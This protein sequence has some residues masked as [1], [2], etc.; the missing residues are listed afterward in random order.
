MSKVSAKSAEI[1]LLLSNKSER[2]KEA[3]IEIAEEIRKGAGRRRIEKMVSD[4]VSGKVKGAEE[5]IIESP[6]GQ[7]IA[8]WRDS[9]LYFAKDIELDKKGLSKMLVSFF[10]NKS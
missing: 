6:S 9:K 5:E 10:D 4:I 8:K 1:I 2:H 3:L 7:V